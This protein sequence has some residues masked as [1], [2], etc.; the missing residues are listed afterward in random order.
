MWLR[1]WGVVNQGGY[2]GGGGPCLER[3][4]DLRSRD[5]A[6]KLRDSLPSA[7]LPGA[8]S[9]DGLSCQL[10]A[11]A[12]GSPGLSLDDRLQRRLHGGA[13]GQAAGPVLPVSLPHHHELHEDLPQGTR[14]RRPSAL[15][16]GRHVRSVRSAMCGSLCVPVPPSRS[17]PQ[18]VCYALA[19][20]PFVLGVS[21][22]S[23]LELT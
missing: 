22:R 19:A 14:R 2:R 10:S 4:Q 1:S 20:S 18:P 17:V 12:P 7:P 3:W 8:L 15:S 13:P 23:Q 11:S 21:S 16:P 6:P 9:C 5:E